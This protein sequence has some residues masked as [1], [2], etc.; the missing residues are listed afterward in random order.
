MLHAAVAPVSV[1]LHLHLVRVDDGHGAV[2]DQQA[3]SSQVLHFRMSWVLHQ[4]TDRI[5]HEVHILLALAI[6]QRHPDRERA[7][8]AVHRLRCTAPESLLVR[9]AREIHADNIW[10]PT[11][12]NNA[13]NKNNHSNGG[14]G[15]IVTKQQQQQQQSRPQ[16][17]D[18][19]PTRTTQPAVTPDSNAIAT[20]RTVPA[21][22]NESPTRTTL[23]RGYTRQ[24]INHY[25]VS[26]M[27]TA[28]ALRTVEA[29]GSAL[30]SS[31]I[32]DSA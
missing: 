15:I 31:S 5:V 6:H 28:S 24:Q 25:E 13:T 30:C 3:C 4:Q 7:E 17:R 16:G 20:N 8:S 10:R 2:A 9:A 26:T 12:V 11:H 21:S 32:C 14:G 22:V 27:I 29:L 1:V 23:A 18:E 19:S